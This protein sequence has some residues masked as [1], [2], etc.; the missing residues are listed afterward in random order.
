MSN[1]AKT[2]ESTKQNDS[3]DSVWGERPLLS[4][5]EARAGFRYAIETVRF[6]LR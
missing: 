2:T 3:D 5:R 4:F 6:R 1:P